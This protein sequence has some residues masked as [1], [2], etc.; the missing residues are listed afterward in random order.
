MLVVLSNIVR[1]KEK[2]ESL[3][4]QQARSVIAIS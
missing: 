2:S 3:A 4:T 1:N